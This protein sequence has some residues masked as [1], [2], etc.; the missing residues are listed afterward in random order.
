MQSE[1]LY[2]LLRIQKSSSVA[3]SEVSDYVPVL[4]GIQYIWHT[5]M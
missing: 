1:S 5:E 3:P 4:N 2:D